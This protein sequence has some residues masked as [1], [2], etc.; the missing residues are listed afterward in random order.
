MRIRKEITKKDV[1]C[2][3]DI[4]TST[5][6]F[7]DFEIATA[8]EIA[9]E[10]VLKGRK[11]G[12]NFIF[13]DDEK[14]VPFAFTAFGEIPCTK[15]RFDLYWIGVHE[16]KR[17]R[18]LGSILLQESEKA[19][20][21]YGGKILYIETSSREKYFPTREFYLKNGYIIETV[22][23]DFYDDGDGKVIYSKRM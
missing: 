21:E 14:G 23:E 3:S 5:G 9:K 2:I 1:K 13:F 7:Y 8:V 4:L 20:S 11:S 19:V 15:K 16:T 12:Y 18:G 22:L 10:A 6:Y 17:G